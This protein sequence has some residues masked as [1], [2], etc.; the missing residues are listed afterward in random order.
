MTHVAPLG[1]KRGKQLTKE[2]DLY[3]KGTASL[4]AQ[5]GWLSLPAPSPAH[6]PL[7][8]TSQITGRNLRIRG[9]LLP[10]PTCFLTEEAHIKPSNS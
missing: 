9:V 5:P 2:S 6:H 8:S 1:M 4:S 10:L 3:L 7:Q